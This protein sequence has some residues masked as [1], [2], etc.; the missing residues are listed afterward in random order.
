MTF[1][2]FKM[3]K[4]ALIFCVTFSVLTC[5]AT[6]SPKHENKIWE[7]SWNYQWEAIGGGCY[8]LLCVQVLTDDSG[9]SIAMNSYYLG[10]WNYEG[11]YLQCNNSNTSQ[12][13]SIC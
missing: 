11:T 6:T 5:F 2:N 4:I 1:Q 10:Y 3:K 13:D 12:W 7:I 9:N 8:Q